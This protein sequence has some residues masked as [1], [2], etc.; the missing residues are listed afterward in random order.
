MN[1]ETP[2]TGE[3]ASPP[4]SV[5]RTGSGTSLDT[6]SHPDQNQDR[7]HR[8]QS[9]STPKASTTNGGCTNTTDGNS[10]RRRRRRYGLSSNVPAM[11]APV[12]NSRWAQVRLRPDGRWTDSAASEPSESASRYG[13][14]RAPPLGRRAVRPSGR[15]VASRGHGA[16]SGRLVSGSAGGREMQR[17]A[18]AHGEANETLCSAVHDCVHSGPLR[19]WPVAVRR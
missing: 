17:R 19:P 13:V 3:P 9:R 7:H 1:T 2:V 16:A 15:A 5:N 10:Q 8:R 18:P 11:N 12:L 14:S 6:R 4:G